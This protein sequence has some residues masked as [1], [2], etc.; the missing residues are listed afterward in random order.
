M[1]NIYVTLLDAFQ[2]YLG[3]DDENAAQVLLDRINRVPFISE[4]ADQGSAM[5]KLVED[6]LHD[7]ISLS[8]YNTHPDPDYFPYHFVSRNG[9]EYNFSFKRSIIDELRETFNGSSS[10]VRFE[11]AIPTRY[12]PVNLY[13]VLDHVS[14]S[15]AY[16]LKTTK[17]Y[18]FP[19]FLDHWQH[20]CYPYLLNN[21][22]IN[23]EM[24][25]Y[26]VT[27]FNNVYREDYPVRDYRGDITLIVERLI[28]F[29]EATREKITDTKILGL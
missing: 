18:T 10:E 17:S 13:G 21:N 7:P 22:G 24:F 8:V 12:G 2:Y 16:D 20:R 9:Q 4:A 15:T 29:L 14:R 25:S 6:L 5:H 11:A 19:K 28:D 1:Y 27:D 23:V 26:V 3:S